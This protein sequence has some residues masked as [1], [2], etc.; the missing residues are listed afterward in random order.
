MWSRQ[1]W[2]FVSIYILVVESSCHVDTKHL[3]EEKTSDACYSILTRSALILP[4]A[5]RLEMT[6]EVLLFHFLKA[7]FVALER[8]DHLM[9]IIAPMKTK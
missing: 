5:C 9:I 8:C 1:D 2:A 7:D 6:S 4:C 3:L